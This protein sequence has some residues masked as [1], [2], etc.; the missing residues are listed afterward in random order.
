MRSTRVWPVVVELD[1][2]A[3]RGEVRVV[4][5]VLDAAHGADGG[6]GVRELRLPLRGGLGREQGG[7]L[8]GQAGLAAGR[9]HQRAGEIGAV[10][11]GAERGPRARF[12][13]GQRH[14]L[15]VG[16][17]VGAPR[18][19]LAPAGRLAGGDTGDR[20]TEHPG[21]A[22]DDRG[23]DERALAGAVAF[24]DGGEDADDRDERAE[25]DREHEVG[26][27]RDGVARHQRHEARVAE[28]RDVVRRLL[29]VRA[30]L[31]E[32]GERAPHQSRLRRQRGWRSRCPAR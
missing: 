7:E 10:D 15:P 29:G 9:V 16:G 4:E 31:P 23:V 21:G 13:C 3:A 32:A 12:G 2:R 1:E 30:A 28:E 19:R 5:Q 20:L 11:R 18:R 6:T 27:G 8:L 26:R 22:V 24:G 17:A 14:Q 25:R